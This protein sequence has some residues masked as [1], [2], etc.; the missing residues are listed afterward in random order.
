MPSRPTVGNA[1]PGVPAVSLP[2]C[3]DPRRNRKRLR[4]RR[5]WTGVLGVAAGQAM[6]W[7]PAS[8]GCY[9]FAAGWR[10]REALLPACRGR[11]ALQL[12]GACSPEAGGKTG[13]L[14]HGTPRTAFPTG[15]GAVLPGEGGVFGM[16][17]QGP[18]SFGQTAPC[19]G[20]RR[21]V[22]AG[23]PDSPAEA[24]R[25]TVTFRRNRNPSIV[26]RADPGAPQHRPLTTTPPGES[27][28]LPPH[29][30][31][32]RPPANP[33]GDGKPFSTRA[34]GARSPPDATRPG[35]P[36]GPA[37]IRPNSLRLSAPATAWPPLPLSRRRPRRW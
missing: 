1:V 21:T 9:E 20:N 32:S 3:A 24:A 10:G 30:Q 12:A 22:G 26:G 4:L 13:V 16:V 15:S 5:G 8:T 2:I 37:G 27:A 6:G 19:P 25:S 7:T 11:H 33:Q 28:P 34:T 23:V 35:D 29:P 17:P 14:P 36:S 18:S 31:Q